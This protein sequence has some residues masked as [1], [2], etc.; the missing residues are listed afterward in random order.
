M[1][2]SS[3]LVTPFHRLL[4]HHSA[5]GG[6]GGPSKV[7]WGLETHP[8]SVLMGQFLGPG[9]SWENLASALPANQGWNWL[10]KTEDAFLWGGAPELGAHGAEEA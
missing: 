9:G 5:C 8:P 7:V 10:R 6:D 3:L 4:H 2:L 1:G